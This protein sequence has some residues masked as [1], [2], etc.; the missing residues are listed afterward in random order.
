[1]NQLYQQ[2][3]HD[4]LL[5]MTSPQQ[6]ATIRHLCKEVSAQ[7]PRVQLLY[8]KMCGKSALVQRRCKP[9]SFHNPLKQLQG[10]CTLGE[11][12]FHFRT[13]TCVCGPWM[14]CASITS[15]PSPWH[16]PSLQ[17][18]ALHRVVLSLNP[19]AILN[20]YQVQRCPC[21]EYGTLSEMSGAATCMQRHDAVQQ[22]ALQLV[23]I[24]DDQQSFV[25]VTLLNHSSEV[26]AMVVWHKAQ[27]QGIP[28][29][30]PLR[31]SP[32][33]MQRHTRTGL[34]SNEM[35]KITLLALQQHQTHS[36]SWKIFTA[37]MPLMTNMATHQVKLT[38]NK[39]RET[40]LSFAS[41]PHIHS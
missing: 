11:R 34:C 22:R 5:V 36:Q 28:H 14:A 30:I 41:V 13:M 16:Q 26:L 19:Q 21:F 37:A 17:V 12:A 18:S 20:L 33:S 32:L 10:S 25:T 1:M 8:I 40:L 23:M 31:P 9:S 4:L 24:E 29:P 15:L 39:W 3:F 7:C 2:E 27:T 6:M 35:V 38:A